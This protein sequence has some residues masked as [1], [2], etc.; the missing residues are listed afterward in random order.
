MNAGGRRYQYH[1]GHFDAT[2]IDDRPGANLMYLTLSANLQTYLVGRQDYQ[3]SLLKHCTL[4][5]NV[6]LS[7]VIAQC[8]QMAYH[9]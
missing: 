9:N 8:S 6:S 2:V 3:P 7:T 1:Q 4:G 5:T